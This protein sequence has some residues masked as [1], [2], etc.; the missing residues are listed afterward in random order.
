MQL[1][2]NHRWFA[3]LL[4]GIFVLVSTS[5]AL[6]QFKAEDF[7]LIPDLSNVKSGPPDPNL[8]VRAR[9]LLAPGEQVGLLQITATM[10]DGWHLYSLTQPAGGSMK[11]EIKP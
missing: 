4:L 8:A 7:Q 5:T 11:S 9:V 2:T 3:A 1:P 10:D 6:A